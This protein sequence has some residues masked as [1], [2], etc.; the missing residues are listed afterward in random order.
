MKMAGAEYVALGP[1]RAAHRPSDS[2]YAKRAFLMAVVVAAVVCGVLL[3]VP[4][5]AGEGG[6]AALAGSYYAV[7][8]PPAFNFNREFSPFRT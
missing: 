1:H 8:K 3:A 4:E 6:D 2:Y 7:T 5:P